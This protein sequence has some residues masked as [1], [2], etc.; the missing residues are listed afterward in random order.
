MSEKDLYNQAKAYL[1]DHYNDIMSL[2]STI[3]TQIESEKSELTL[4]QKNALSSYYTVV[5]HRILDNFP[6]IS[7][8]ER[9]ISE[10]RDLE[11]TNVDNELAVVILVES[12]IHELE[13][14]GLVTVSKK[15]D[16]SKILTLTKK[17]RDVSARIGE[18]IRT[19]DSLDL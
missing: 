10:N 15:D 19:S 17:G 2:Y 5:S 8:I 3:F 4:S 9:K 11:L 18:D 12:K 14:K 1:R 7:K 6:I 13:T 16:G